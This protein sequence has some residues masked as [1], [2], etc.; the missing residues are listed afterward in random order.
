MARR[1]ARLTLDTLADL[2]EEVRCCVQWELDPVSRHRLPDRESAA[3][4]KEAWVSRVLLDWG[5]CGR[6]VY[7]DG[8]PAGFVTYA[9]PAYLAGT[10]SLPTAPVSDDAVQVAAAQVFEPWA[11]TGLGRLLMQE[12]V[13]D[14]VQRG[15]IRAV[16]AFGST[17]PR[18]RASAVLSGADHQCLLPVEFLQRVG[19]KTQRPHP[20][21]PRMRL[22]LKSVVTWREEVEGAL[23][24][25]LG[26][27]RP[28]RAPRPVVGR[29][30]AVGRD[31]QAM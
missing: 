18:S 28:T 29:D 9:P 5:S 20:R 27:V 25:L 31:A 19:F 12:V 3:A 26:V 10:A 7:V 16:E 30:A 14:L 2:P 21:T 4:E 6:V 24:R 22:E 1:V 8:E 23:E 15:G 11:G 17:R 13:K